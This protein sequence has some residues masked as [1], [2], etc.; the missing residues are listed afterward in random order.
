[1]YDQKSISYSSEGLDI[2]MACDAASGGVP[3]LF[4]Y[5]HLQSGVRIWLHWSHQGFQPLL[6]HRFRLDIPLT[7]MDV[8][9]DASYVVP[10][11]HTSMYLGSPLPQAYMKWNE[12]P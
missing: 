2:R 8:I 10:T 5:E 9:N 7:V 12:R 11:Q 6:S 4:Y 3:N 1:M